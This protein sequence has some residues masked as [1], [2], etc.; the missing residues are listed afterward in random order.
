MRLVSLVS[1][2]STPDRLKEVEKFFS[3]NPTPA[4]ARTIDQAK[5]RIRLNMAWL[6]RNSEEVDIFLEG[7]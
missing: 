3:T 7:A 1:G 2:F 6:K 4:A 5:E